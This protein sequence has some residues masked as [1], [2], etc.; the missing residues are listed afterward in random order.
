MPV[1]GSGSQSFVSINSLNSTNRK[2]EHYFYEHFSHINDRQNAR[3]SS[4]STQ[5][6]NTGR[7]FRI[8]QAAKSKSG[9]HSDISTPFRKKR[10]TPATQYN[11][12]FPQQT[13][14]QTKAGQ[15][16]LRSTSELRIRDIPP[17]GTSS[18]SAVGAARTD[19][20]TDCSTCNA[21]SSPA[22][23]KS[24]DLSRTS[25]RPEKSGFQ[26]SPKE[27]NA[28][29]LQGERSPED[30][31]GSETVRTPPP[32]A[33]AA[34]TETYRAGGGV[35]RR[36]RVRPLFTSQREIKDK[37]NGAEKRRNGDIYGV[38]NPNEI[39]PPRLWINEQSRS[40]YFSTFY[41]KRTTAARQR[42]RERSR[43]HDATDTEKHERPPRSEPRDAVRGAPDASLASSPR[44]HPRSSALRRTREA[45]F[46]DDDKLFGF[47]EGDADD[48][49]EGKCEDLNSFAQDKK[50]EGQEWLL[51]PAERVVHVV[52]TVVTVLLKDIND[53]PPVF[54]N[55]TM[56]GEVQENG[57][58]SEYTEATEYARE[59]VS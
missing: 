26:E 5:Y 25:T 52:E 49:D 59:G 48:A 27:S 50:E 18:L 12:M 15:R 28:R 37:P 34:V 8:V 10:P 43:L 2:H 33:R 38:S 21:G 56:Y 11:D 51:K 24:R 4:L 22:S 14:R 44:S 23:P 40:N 42:P 19:E 3:Y 9:I 47:S 41:H 16:S 55:A 1:S 58:I 7:N 17:P 6:L 20:R 35:A 39:P 13:Q 46:E 36:P 31:T 29:V 32:S 45:E 30:T 53:N 57:P 54:P